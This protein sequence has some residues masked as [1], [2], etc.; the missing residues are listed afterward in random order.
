MDRAYISDLELRP[1]KVVKHFRAVYPL[2]DTSAYRRW[3]EID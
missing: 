3:A 2:T 1:F